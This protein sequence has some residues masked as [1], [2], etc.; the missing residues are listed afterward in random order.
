MQEIFSH[1]R[2]I[3]GAIIGA[4]SDPPNENVTV[5]T[6]SFGGII[7]QYLDVHSYGTESITI[8]RNAYEAAG[9]NKS[10]FISIMQSTRM[11]TTVA[12]WLFDNIDEESIDSLRTRFVHSNDLQY[13]W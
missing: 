4:F 2:N 12:S 10:E 13:G 1:A 11:A 6:P 9:G 5:D 7:D 8:I 3:S